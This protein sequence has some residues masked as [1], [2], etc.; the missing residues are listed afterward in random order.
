[1]DALAS[2]YYWNGSGSKPLSSAPHLYEQRVT[3]TIN[4]VLFPSRI[5]RQL[6]YHINGSY[7]KSY[8]QERHGWKKKPGYQSTCK[9]S[10]GIL[11]H[12]KEDNKCNIMKFV[13]NLQS[14]GDRKEKIQTVTSDETSLCPCCSEMSRNSTAS[15][16][17][18]RKP[19]PLTGYRPISEDM[20]KER[21]Q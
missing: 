11:S 4:G 20:P 9:H 13:Y 7:L 18:Y 12:F 19:F 21:C 8:L 6:R 2:D 1:M 15:A 17:L 14:I 16:A 5:D 10:G 3:I